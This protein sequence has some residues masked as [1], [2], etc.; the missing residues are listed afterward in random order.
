MNEEQDVSE[1]TTDNNSEEEKHTHHELA[2]KTP[3][4]EQ[5]TSRLGNAVTETEKYTE[6]PQNNTEKEEK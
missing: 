3:D 6:L 2:D 1:T 4:S 5:E